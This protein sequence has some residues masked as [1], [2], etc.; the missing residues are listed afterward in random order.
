MVPASFQ[1]VAFDV[2]FVL[3]RDGWTFA[4][5]VLG[6][7]RGNLFAW[8]TY[9][10]PRDELHWLTAGEQAALGLQTLH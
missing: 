3:L 2:A 7:E 10:T 4:R 8:L 9:G 1:A 6:E 5:R